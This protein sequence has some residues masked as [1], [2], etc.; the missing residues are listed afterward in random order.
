[1]LKR[2]EYNL[3]FYVKVVCISNRSGRLELFSKK[4]FLKIRKIHMKTPVPVSFLIKLQAFGLQLFKSETLAQVFSCNFAKFL[5]TPIFI[6]RLRCQCSFLCGIFLLSKIS[7]KI[8]LTN[9]TFAFTFAE[10]VT[11]NTKWSDVILCNCS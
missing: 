3:V 2:P 7:S 9:A 8:R 10:H 1:M 11:L 4:V 5:G 6:E